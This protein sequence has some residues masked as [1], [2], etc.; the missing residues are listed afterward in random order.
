MSMPGGTGPSKTNG[1]GSLHGTTAP[2][3]RYDTVVLET[4]GDTVPRNSDTSGAHDHRA[5]RQTSADPEV[6]VAVRYR[7]ARRGGSSAGQSRG[8]IIPGSRVRT[9]PAPLSPRPAQ[10][11]LHHLDRSPRPQRTTVT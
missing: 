2:L 5:P 6:P 10:R 1:D 4:V 11:F 3:D 7:T 9:P 8:L